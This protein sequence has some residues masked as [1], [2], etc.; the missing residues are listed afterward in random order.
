[1][2]VSETALT[3][4]E[5]RS[6]SPGGRLGSERLAGRLSGAQPRQANE[7]GACVPAQFALRID[8]TRQSVQRAPGRAGLWGLIC[9]RRETPAAAGGPAGVIFRRDMLRDWRG[10][11][12]ITDQNI[13]PGRTT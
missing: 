10:R 9:D 4:R 13:I 2:Q 6:Q 3:M 1:M 7:A 5:R 8:A 11:H 12:Q